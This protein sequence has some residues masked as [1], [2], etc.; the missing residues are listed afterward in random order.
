MQYS[1]KPKI[2]LIYTGGTIG[3]HRDSEGVLRPPE[4]SESFL[5]VAP[6]L[7]DL[8]DFDFV[9]LLKKDSTNMNPSDWTKIADEI[10][11][12]NINRPQYYDGFVVAHG[13]DTMHFSA[14]AVA[15]AL[16]RNLNFPVVFTGA[17]TP[18]DVQHGDARVNLLRAFKV[19]A[20]DIA[21]V[22]IS[23]GDYVF[24][25][26]RA[27]KKDERKFDAF[28]APAH[29]PL[30][31]ITEE[32]IASHFATKRKDRNGNIDLKS[33]FS[34]GYIPSISYPWNGT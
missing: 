20:E 31:Y 25:G 18:P 10:Y 12:I 17:Q 27:Q 22:V 34:K 26:C 1:G 30:A 13:T 23:F 7:G 4:D 29:F 33:K 28:E 5:Q 24:R 21:E 11:N 32:I 16:G 19:A 9:P 6:E 8:A 15:L 3:M 14:S 2:C